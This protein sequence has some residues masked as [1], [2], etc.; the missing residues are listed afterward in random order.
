MKIIDQSHE[1]LHYA[2]PIKLIEAA[3]RT[4]YKSE[5]KI[6]EDSADSFA[7]RIRRSG[8]HSVFEHAHICFKIR[9]VTGYTWMKHHQLNTYFKFSP[10]R[11]LISGNFRAWGEFL[12]NCASTQMPAP[13]HDIT[14]IAEYLSD[15]YPAIFHRYFHSTSSKSY[16]PFREDEM[17]ILEKKAHATRTC[18]FITNR[19][20]THEMVRHRPWAYS[21]ESSRYVRYDGEMDFIRPVWLELHPCEPTLHWQKA[22]V[23]SE[24]Y[25]K[26]LLDAGWKAQRA[27]EVLP[28]SLKTE[29]VCTAPLCEWKHMLGLRTSKAAHPQIRALMQPVLVEL[30][31][32]LPL[33]FT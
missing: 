17:T 15:V 11:L 32:E 30:K 7:R 24:L 5:D 20:V 1:F 31:A 29:I 26:Q 3:G 19:G 8:H 18:R 4:C 33:I 28:N 21:Q 16:V 13:P 25:Y 9:S 6:T 10:G 2:D 14:K 22:M 12:T 23:Y 27:R